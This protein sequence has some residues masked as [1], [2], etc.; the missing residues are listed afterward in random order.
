LTQALSDPEKRAIYDQYGEEGL[1]GMPPPGSQ[2]RISTAAASSGPS[3]FRYN[4]SDSDDF[5]ADFMASNKPYS[6]EKDRTRFPSR[7]HGTST[8]NTRSETSSTQQ[9]GSSASTS[10]LEKPRP[11]ERALPCTLEELYNGTKWRMKITRNV[12]KPDGYVV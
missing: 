12:A 1:K 3:N 4:R 5:F 11:V 9:K 10:Q 6:F 2:S 7:S 8:R